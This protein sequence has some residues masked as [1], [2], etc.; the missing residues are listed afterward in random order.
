VDSRMSEKLGNIFQNIVCGKTDGA[1]E[2]E[3]EH[4]FA[5]FSCFFLSMVVIQ[6]RRENMIKKEKVAA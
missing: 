4:A 1:I 6:E 3:H 5:F 2:M